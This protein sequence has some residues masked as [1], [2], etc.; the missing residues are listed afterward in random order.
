MGMHRGDITYQC[1]NCGKAFTNNADL[2]NHNSSS[3][4]DAVSN[5][6][7]FVSHIGNHTGEKSYQCRYCN[8]IF[9]NDGALLIHEKTHLIAKNIQFRVTINNLLFSLNFPLECGRIVNTDGSCFYDS[10]IANIEDPVI[11]QSVAFNAKNI[12]SIQ[13]LRLSIANFMEANTL[14]HGLEQFQMQRDCIC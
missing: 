8:K 10:V 5:V 11:R 13:D 14:L 1:I 6:E 4:N 2:L 12:T 9:L 3:C 7:C